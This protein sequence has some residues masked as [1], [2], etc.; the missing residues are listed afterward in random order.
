[1]FYM[2]YIWKTR[3]SICQIEVVYQHAIIKVMS[4]KVH[5]K[6]HAWLMAIMA[7]TFLIMSCMQ[8][9]DKGAK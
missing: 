6:H 7:G 1:M 2:N 9:V 5:K 8:S 3:K 4:N